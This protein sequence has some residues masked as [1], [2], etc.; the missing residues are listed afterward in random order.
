M[1]A[2]A[3][4]LIWGPAASILNAFLLVGLDLAPRDALH[5]AWSDNSRSFHSWLSVPSCREWC[6]RSGRPR[7]AAGSSGPE[8]SGGGALA[9]RTDVFD[10]LAGGCDVECTA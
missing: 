7:C 8:R 5:E 3:S 9:G 2:N 4:V 6:L 1:A 10:V